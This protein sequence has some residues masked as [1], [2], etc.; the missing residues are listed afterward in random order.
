MS[1]PEE[2]PPSGPTQLY[3]SVY[4]GS[5][6]VPHC[7]RIRM[8]LEKHGIEWEDIDLA[9]CENKRE[10]RADMEARSESKELPQLFLRGKFVGAGTECLEELMYL[11]D[12]GEV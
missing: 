1:S 3:W 5:F 2:P 11:N 10:R 12:M 8:I 4:S 6:V 7:E 9:E